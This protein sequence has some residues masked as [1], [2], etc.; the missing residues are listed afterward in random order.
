MRA[1]DVLVRI[2][3]HALGEG[4]AGWLIAAERPEA[5]VQMELRR[6]GRTFVVSI[7]PEPVRDPR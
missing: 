6:D 7:A 5:P 3:G 4:A 1:G 2:A